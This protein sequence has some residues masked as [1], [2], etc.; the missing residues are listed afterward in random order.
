[1]KKLI[2]VTVITAYLALCAAVWPQTEAVKETPAPTPVPAVNAQKTTVV[3]P[4][5]EVETE[6]PAEEEKNEIP[7]QEPPQKASPKPKSTPIETPTTPEV[8]PT[9]EPEHVTEPIAEPAPAQIVIEP[10]PGDMVY[11]SGFGWIESQG[12]NHVEYAEDMYEN[13]NKIG[14]MG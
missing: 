2:M 7:K 1:M 12:P 6:L 4:K 14:I 3:E 8:R 11:V 10:Q 13:G 9:P 5:T